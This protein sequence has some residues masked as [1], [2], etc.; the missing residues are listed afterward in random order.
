MLRRGLRSPTASRDQ[1]RALFTLCPP[2]CQAA[3]PRSEKTRPGVTETPNRV[4]CYG[5]VFVP[6]RPRA[7][8]FAP[9]LLSARRHVKR[10][11]LDRKKLAR[12]SLRRQIG[13]HATARSSFPNGLARPTSRLVYS[14]PAAMSSGVP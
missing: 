5:E 9:C 11:S 6:Q 4:A 10:R 1:L 12:E 7:T 14:L 8:N 3:F 13:S 2:P